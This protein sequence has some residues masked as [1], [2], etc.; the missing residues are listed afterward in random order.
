MK[1]FVIVGFTV[2][3]GESSRSDETPKGSREL[4]LLA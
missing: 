1:H 4:C 3:F 2:P